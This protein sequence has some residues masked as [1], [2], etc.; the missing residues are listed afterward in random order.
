MIATVLIENVLIEA[1]CFAA[2]WLVALRLRDVSLIDAV[3][4]LE[5]HVEGR[6]RRRK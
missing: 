1:A 5:R 3:I 4:A 6:M 2:L